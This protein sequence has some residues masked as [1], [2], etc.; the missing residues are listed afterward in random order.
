MVMKIKVASNTIAAKLAG[1]IAKTVRIGEKVE[2]YAVGSRPTYITVKAIAIAGEYLEAE[3]IYLTSS[4]SSHLEQA[5]DKQSLLVIKF[6]IMPIKIQEIRSEIT[7]TIN[8]T[9]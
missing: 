5:E 4:I 2:L 3:H 8:M 1:A 9:D 6:S 7:N